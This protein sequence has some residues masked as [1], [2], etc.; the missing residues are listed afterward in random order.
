MFYKS[1]WPKYNN[2]LSNT[3][4]IIAIIITISLIIFIIDFLFSNI[5]EFFYKF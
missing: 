5:I 3:I 4:S 1:I 2:V